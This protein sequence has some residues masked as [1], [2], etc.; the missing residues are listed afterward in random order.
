MRGM[1]NSPNVELKP[2]QV[3]AI[4]KKIP[5]FEDAFLMR[6]ELSSRDR[7]Q[8]ELA[9]LLNRRTLTEQITHNSMTRP[10]TI[11][12]DGLFEVCE[13][14]ARAEHGLSRFLAEFCLNPEID[15]TIGPWYFARLPAVL[16]EFKAEQ[17]RNAADAVAVTSIGSQIYEALDY[18]RE[19]RCF[20]L[21][22]GNCGRGK[23]FA[24]RSWCAGRPGSARFI[25]VPASND[26]HSFFLALA[27][28]LGVSANIKSKSFELRERVEQAIGSGDLLLCFDESAR[29]WPL[30]NLRDTTP[31]RI[32][33][34]MS[35]ADRGVPIALIVTPQFFQNKD[36]AQQACG[37]NSDQFFRRFRQVVDVPDEITADDLRS[38]CASLLPSA[39]AE[40]RAAIVEAVGALPQPLDALDSIAKRATVL[41]SK[42]RREQPGNEH[43]TASFQ[44]MTRSQSTLARLT[45]PRKRQAASASLPPS[46]PRSEGRATSPRAVREMEFPD[47]NTRPTALLPVPVSD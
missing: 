40:L 10:E 33:W 8:L 28:C 21:I 29:L 39:G 20:S 11:S 30:K 18:A 43:V 35:M 45:A 25:E 16:R 14:A 3:Q 5:D 6:G 19:A 36:R 27:E 47:R 15:P 44:F 9:K 13:E 12:S 38:V 23:S 41:A 26:D 22:Y 1:K 2:K 46:P 37:W 32:A 31:S 34:V 42:A 7:S 24:G 17:E 4:R